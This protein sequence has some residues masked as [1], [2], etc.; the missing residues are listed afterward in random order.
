MTEQEGY[1]K[2][3]EYLGKKDKDENEKDLFTFYS[4]E[5]NKDDANNTS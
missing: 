1:E 5:E 4:N 3:M 2:I